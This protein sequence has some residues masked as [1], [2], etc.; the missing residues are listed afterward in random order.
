MGY[1]G[2]SHSS[3]SPSSSE[4]SEV[5]GHSSCA[6]EVSPERVPALSSLHIHRHHPS[7]LLKMSSYLLDGLGPW[8]TR[9]P[10]IIFGLPPQDVKLLPV[11]FHLKGV[12]LDHG[13]R[14]LQGA[15]CRGEHWHL[16]LP[17]RRLPHLCSG[18]PWGRGGEA[19]LSLQCAG[20]RRGANGV[21]KMA[22]GGGVKPPEFPLG[23]TPLPSTTAPWEPEG[24]AAEDKGQ[25]RR[26][27]R[28]ERAA[29]RQHTPQFAVPST[30]TCAPA[31][32]H[33]S[34]ELCKVPR[35]LPHCSPPTLG[36]ASG[37]SNALHIP[38]CLRDTARVSSAH[39]ALCLLGLGVPV[40]VKECQCRG[41]AA[42]GGRRSHGRGGR[43][44]PALRLRPRG[45]GA[46]CR[47]E[48][49]VMGKRRAPCWGPPGPDEPRLG[50][51]AVAG[52]EEGAKEAVGAAPAPAALRGRSPRPWKSRTSWRTR[53]CWKPERVRAAGRGGEGGEA[54]VRGGAG[55]GRMSREEKGLKWGGKGP[56]RRGRGSDGGGEAGREE[57]LPGRGP[58]GA[59]T[60]EGGGRSRPGAGSE[61]RAVPSGTCPV[62][63]A[64][65]VWSYWLV[66]LPLKKH[67][68][69]LP[70]WF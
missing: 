25:G 56:A 6:Q 18:C 15:L 11:N 55:W 16:S 44:L 64:G 34:R 19:G 54:G 50:A 30:T 49:R 52:L 9:Q 4:H 46:R 2:R 22:P 39:T 60:P 57:R 38:A 28:K 13:H 40:T 48:Q 31:A 69:L 36:W 45:G 41:G 63:P 29:R 20:P 70:P 12:A 67:P 32:Y 47:G 51:A 58:G 7:S 33:L 35:Y 17:L 59:G 24:R 61:S 10:H 53:C 3:S 5:S 62:P 66:A 26:K 65:S 21:S 42:W 37:R 8:H 23:L 14:R 1:T 68:F 27:K 43:A